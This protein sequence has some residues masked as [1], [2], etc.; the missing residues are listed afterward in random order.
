MPM[1]RLLLALF[2]TLTAAGAWAQGPRFDP[3]DPSPASEAALVSA[4]TSVAPGDSV[5]VALHIDIEPTWH[6][7]W[8]NPADT[9]IPVTV[10]WRLPDGWRAGPLRFPA[11]ERIE[12]SG[13]VSFAHEDE[14][15]L[16]A[17]V[18]VPPDAA[19]QATLEGT[20]EWLICADICVPASQELSLSLDVRDGPPAPDPAWAERLAAARDALPAP[21]SGW[22]AEAHHGDAAYLLRLIPPPGWSGSLDAA[23]VFARDADVVG[24]EASAWARDG[25]AWTLRLAASPAA[26]APAERFRAVVAVPEGATLAPDR[27]VRAMAIDAPVLVGAIPEPA[28]GGRVSSVWMALLL[29]FGGGVLLNLMPCV[30]PILSIKILGFVEGRAATRAEMRRH[31][32]A[33]G[34]GVLVSFVAL[35]ALLLALRAAGEGVGWGFQ[36]Q[37]PGIVAALAG[38]MVVL[39]LWML[40]IVEGGGALAAAGARLDRGH[41][42]GG[43]FASGVLAS[44]VA[45]PC[46]A[47][48]M[49]AAVGFALLRPAPVALSVFVALAVGMALPYV[50]L[51]LF[52]SWLARLPRP[53]AWMETL[54]QALA[55][56]LLLTAVWLVWVFGQQVGVDGAALLVASL[57]LVGLAAWL[58]GRWPAATASPRTRVVTRGLA[59]LALV[60]AVGMA[61]WGTRLAPTGV[62][63]ATEIA[64]DGWEP[65]D[66]ARIDALTAAG[67]P[68]FVDFTATWCWTCQVNKRTTLHTDR[69]AAAF[70]AH[71]VARVRADWTSR[72]PEI[73]AALERLG[74]GSV[75]VYVLYPG[76]DAAPILLPEVLRPGLVLDALDLLP[77]RTARS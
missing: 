9:G 25:E 41:G 15:T 46:S 66:A 68:V 20:A 43:A 56:P 24:Y 10:D 11:P 72:D 36:L 33:F 62:A 17:T 57:V 71:G 2:W 67:T 60:G 42:A 23:E 29:A 21:V 7:Y 52:P 28:G 3:D 1:H 12:A 69:V 27:D 54:R 49:G 70:E 30:F 22:T 50:L 77:T 45:T 61:A 39:G 44:I 5:E 35:A 75:P 19:G 76:G 16:F 73:T 8:E 47:P 18:W 4:V 31:G 55:F 13:I 59:A 65:Y 37:S 53:G 26:E 14:A 64:A 38:L 51:S 34:A 6:V 48:F 58:V 40:G 32:L 63:A 74:R